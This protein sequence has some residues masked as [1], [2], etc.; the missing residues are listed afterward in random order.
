MAIILDEQSNDVLDEMGNEVLDEFGL[1]PITPIKN[2]GSWIP[3]PVGFGYVS[4]FTGVDLMTDL[5]VTLT[6]DLGIALSTQGRQVV[7]KYPG[8]WTGTGV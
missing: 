1:S 3:Q 5:G 7:G 6:T 8:V 4:T 2:P